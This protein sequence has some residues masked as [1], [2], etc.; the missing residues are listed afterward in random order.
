MSR[1]RIFQ[2]GRE[3]VVLFFDEVAIIEKSSVRMPQLPG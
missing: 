2:D 3:T 1:G